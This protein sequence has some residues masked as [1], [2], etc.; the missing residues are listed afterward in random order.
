MTPSYFKLAQEID[1]SNV[2][3]V[4]CPMSSMSSEVH[5]ELGIRTIPFAH[6]YHPEAGLV[7]QRRVPRKQLRNLEKVVQSYIG[8]ACD[9]ADDDCSSPYKP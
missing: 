3:F 8:G 4:D 5:K 7:E 6:V 2:K 1:E 9:V